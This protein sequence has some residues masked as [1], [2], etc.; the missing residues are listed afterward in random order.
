MLGAICLVVAFFA[1]RAA[2]RTLRSNPFREARSRFA[3]AEKAKAAGS[4]PKEAPRQ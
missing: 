2:F 3:A 1:A 4:K